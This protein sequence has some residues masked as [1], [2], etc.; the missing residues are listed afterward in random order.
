[1]A[2]S[3]SL[4]L[5]PRPDSASEA[6]NILLSEFS[7]SFLPTLEEYIKQNGWKAPTNNKVA[8]FVLSWSPIGLFGKAYEPFYKLSTN[9]NNAK[10]AYDVARAT[11][12]LALKNESSQDV[13]TSVVFTALGKML[14]IRR[15]CPNSSRV[16]DIIDEAFEKFLSVTPALMPINAEDFKKRMQTYLKEE[17]RIETVQH[18]MEDML[19]R[20]IVKFS[21]LSPSSHLL[22]QSTY[23]IT[24]LVSGRIPPNLLSVEPHREQKLEIRF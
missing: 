12:E 14:K 15:M 11:I 2:S 24:D 6:K 1:M 5:K 10:K 21:K 3:S 19:D 17:F 18:T 20:L 13:I 23:P 4:L 8:N 9:Q 16:G 7:R 22:E